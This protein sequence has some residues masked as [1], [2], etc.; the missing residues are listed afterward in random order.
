MSRYYRLSNTAPVTASCYLERR[1]SRRHTMAAFQPNT[2]THNELHSVSKTFREEIRKL[3]PVVENSLVFVCQK[4]TSGECK[5][6]LVLE[7]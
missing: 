7:L 4:E 2:L 1:L 6:D 5:Y 3:N